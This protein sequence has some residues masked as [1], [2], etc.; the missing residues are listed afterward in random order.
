MSD[1]NCCPHCGKHFDLGCGRTCDEVIRLEEERDRYRAIYERTD[2]VVQE[3]DKAKNQLAAISDDR[4]RLFQEMSDALTQLQ[5][6]QHR[7]LLAIIV[8]VKIAAD[9]PHET[10]GKLARGCLEKLNR[11][12]AAADVASEG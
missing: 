1:R 8:L 10:S 11:K 6:E 7:T 9:Y 2:E 4:D 3:R 12:A 5:T